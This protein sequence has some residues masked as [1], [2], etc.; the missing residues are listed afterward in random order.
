MGALEELEK[1]I[2]L[3]KGLDAVNATFWDAMTTVCLDELQAF[4]F[5]L[6]F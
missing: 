5:F 4:S 6:F 3:H 1:D 2:A